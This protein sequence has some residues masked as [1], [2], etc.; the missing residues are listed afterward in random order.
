MEGMIRC[1]SKNPIADLTPKVFN[2]LVNDEYFTD[3]TLCS[4]DGKSI[5]GHRVILSSFST[6]FENMLRNDTN[7]N[8]KI[9]FNKLSLSNL[10]N[11]KEFM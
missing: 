9:Y 5:K 1:L 10:Q 6:V 3:V 2:K 8:T 11:L 7:S 4:K